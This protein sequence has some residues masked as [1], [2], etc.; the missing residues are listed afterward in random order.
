MVVDLDETLVHYDKEKRQFFVRP[1]T[2]H[3]LREVSQYF[4]IVIFT[5]ATQDYTDY[6]LQRV[7]I[8]QT[9]SHKLYRE[10]TTAGR[11][12]IVKD[13]SRLGRDLS[14]TIIID[15]NPRSF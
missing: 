12:G 10:H 3:F 5:A 9:I 15:N 8:E 4:E 6:I 2:R 1:Y 13:I 11:L 14:K 7:D